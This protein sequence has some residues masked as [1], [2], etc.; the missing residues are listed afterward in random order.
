MVT[1]ILSIVISIL[2][3]VISILITMLSSIRQE[4]SM[5]LFIYLSISICL[6]VYVCMYA[7]ICYAHTYVRAHPDDSHF[8][9]VVLSGVN[10]GLTHRYVILSWS[11]VNWRNLLITIARR[12]HT[13]NKIQS[14]LRITNATSVFTSPVHN[15][16]ITTLGVF[17]SL[18]MFDR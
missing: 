16:L 13:N 11:K 8:Y 9:K 7:R 3:M 18:I 17:R 10:V 6:S 5:Y 14:R 15:T 12:T 4:V 2:S 1:S